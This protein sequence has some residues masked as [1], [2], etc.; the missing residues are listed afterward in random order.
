MQF[1][2]LG[3][4]LV[5]VDGAEVGIPGGR[6]RVLLAALLMRAGNTVS[7]DALATA[8]WDRASP[9]TAATLRSYVMR[10]RRTLGPD[11]GARLVARPAGYLLDV[12]EDEVDL[13]RFTRLCRDGGAALRAGAWAQASELLAAALALWRG[14]PLADVPSDL[15]RREHAPGLEQERLRATEWRIDA[16]LRLGRGEDVVNEL[17]EL[18]ARH[19]TRE[20]GQGQLMRALYQAGRQTEALD[21]YRRVRARLVEE[22]GVEPGA[23]LQDLHRR[24][25]EADPSLAGDPSD[26]PGPSEAADGASATPPAPAQLPAD[27]TAFTGRARELGELDALWTGPDTGA[28]HDAASGSVTLITG[29]A[30][31]GKTALAIHW[32]HRA[33]H[34]YPDGQLYVNLRGYDPGEPVAASDA[35]AGFLAALGVPARDIP[36][37]L[38]ERAARF[39]TETA[40]RHLL[41]IL[42]NAGSVPQVRPL[43]PGSAACAVLVTSRDSLS[44]LVVVDGARRLDVEALTS[45]ESVLLLR[46]LIGGRVDDHPEAA[47]ALAARCTWLPL[48]LRV[49]AELAAGRPTT[50]L[51]TLAAELTDHRR[52]L[53]LL[54][55]GGDPHADVATVFSWSYRQLPGDVARVFRLLGLNPGSSTDPFAAAALA[56]TTA[57]SAGAALDQLAR[58]HLVQRVDSGRYGLHDLLRAYAAGLAADLDGTDGTGAALSRLFDY[59]LGAANLAVDILHPAERA[60]RPA[61]TPPSAPLPALVDPATALPWLDTELP[62]LV[63]I[64]AHTARHGWP[65]HTVTLAEILYP[66]LMGARYD[67]AVAVY[68]HTDEAAGRLGDLRAAALAQ[69][70]LGAANSLAGRNELATGQLARSLDLFRAAGDP[71]GQ[72][73]VLN[74]LSV[75]E[76]EAGDDGSALDHNEQARVHFRLAGDGWGEACALVNLGMFAHRLGRGTES[77]D[78]FEQAVV[79]FRETGDRLREARTLTRLAVLGQQFGQHEQSAEHLRYSLELHRTLGDREG[80]AWTVSVLGD[81]EVL[82]GRYAQAAAHHE[83]SL[84]LARRL[85]SPNLEG[86]ALHSLGRLSAR[87]G[88]PQR[89]TEYYQQALAVFR[90]AGAGQFDEVGVLN[91]LGEATAALGLAHEA[92]THYTA[93]LRIATD[94]SSGEGEVRAHL[95]LGA[96]HRELG[97]HPAVRRHYQQALAVAVV[98]GTAVPDEIRAYL[99]DDPVDPS[100]GSRDRS[101]PL[102]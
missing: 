5:R 102:A 14:A 61:V 56:D 8:V 32:A 36:V 90:S 78:R 45:D 73:R 7:L 89:A 93:A 38:D 21:A 22:L 82:L 92:I 24:I 96:A 94:V 29:T 57:S 49:I 71:H 66:Y 42:D 58:A 26:R 52:R 75:V 43:L 25:L 81:V 2:I 40:R 28:G 63:T 10:L 74:N 85:G 4:L 35:L 11:A 91:D 80:E 37:G 55:I 15:L 46:K 12:T 27:V 87:R 18:T 67:D 101:H 60:H 68:R 64:A 86:G 72:A 16:D 6:Q 30:G 99:A 53:D 84:S 70:G 76:A 1:G 13:L 77:I 20:Y 79:L 59:Y 41:I 83:Q 34:R 31:V 97:D 19:P 100:V 23:P 17:R 47:Q 9:D 3:P 44:G 62:N 65:G 50:P 88:A 33:R 51:A 98:S 69:L 54:G 39:R 95:G 48:A